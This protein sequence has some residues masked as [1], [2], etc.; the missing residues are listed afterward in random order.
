MQKIN[1]SLKNI[2][3]NLFPKYTENVVEK[4]P[5]IVGF[6]KNRISV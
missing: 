6:L 4:N 5:S 3:K 1:G 2:N